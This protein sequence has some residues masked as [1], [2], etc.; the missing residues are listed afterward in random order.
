MRI[1]ILF[2]IAVL[3]TVSSCSKKDCLSLKG[4]IQKEVRYT[5]NFDTVYVNDYFQ[6]Y[7]KSDTINKIEI[8]TFSNFIKNVDTKVFD[9]K[10]IISDLNACRFLKG[11]KAKKITISSKNI[12]KIVVNDGI[13]LYSVDT[14]KFPYLLIEYLSEIGSCD[15]TVDNKQT[16]IACWYSAGKFKV[17]GKTNYL[18]IGIAAMASV[19]AYDTEADKVYA[20]NSSLGDIQV[21][22]KKS[23]TALI[24][25]EGDIFYKGNPASLKLADSSGTGKLIRIVE[26]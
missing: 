23:L 8:E 19:L 6:V 18:Y 14:L 11:Y 25:N 13:E 20:V 17:S 4:D 1:T 12:R 16:Q 10:L 3:I 26:D 2:A 7:L 9:N 22:A 24:R 5:A 15:L 21:N